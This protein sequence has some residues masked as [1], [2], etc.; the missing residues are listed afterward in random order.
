MKSTKGAKKPQVKEV[1]KI[2]KAELKKNL[3]PKY[4]MYYNSSL[5]IDTTGNLSAVISNSQGS[6]DTTHVGDQI[7]LRSLYFNYYVTCADT[8]NVVR[9]L[10]IQ[11][12]GYVPS[13]AAD[14]FQVSGSDSVLTS[15][16]HHDYMQTGLI[17]VLYD[18]LH[19]LD[20]YN[21][22]QQHKGWVPM[23]YVKSKVQFDAGG[24]SVLTGDIYM[25]TISDS[26]A[27]SH[28]T[29]NANILY[30]YTDA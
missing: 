21:P 26:S 4:N 30:N 10:L 29:I 6:S 24:S 15:P 17:T 25:I 22:L 11:T 16:Y 18:R 12:K 8:F 23:K 13:A 27:A 19:C 5:G 1:R 3:E 14:I 28:P 20:T 7:E 9:V 2:I